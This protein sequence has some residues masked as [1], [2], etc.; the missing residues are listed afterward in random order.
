M[1]E[2][3]NIWI[4]LLVLFAFIFIIGVIVMGGYGMMGFGFGFGWLFMI[5]FWG[6]VIWLVYELV[7]RTQL[8][9]THTSEDSFEI[10]KRRYA[11]G[12]ITKKQYEK[13]KRD[14]S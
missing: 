5:V 4:G 2:N 1:E 11:K 6:L 13:M 9:T 14:L 12:E 8:K 7:N 10:L 3:K